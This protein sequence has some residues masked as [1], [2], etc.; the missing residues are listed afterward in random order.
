MPITHSQGATTFTGESVAYFRVCALK[1][2]VG[3]E[4]K[5]I[6]VRRGPVVWKK[7]QREFDIHPATRQGVYNW[8]CAKVEELA[9]QQEH[10]DDRNG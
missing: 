3:L 9:A 10:I 5:G 8:L 1:T 4:M 2:L 6:R 7:V